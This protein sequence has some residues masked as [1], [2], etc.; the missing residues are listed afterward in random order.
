M[1]GQFFAHPF[2]QAF[3]RVQIGTVGW[4]LN[5]GKAQGFRFLPDNRRLAMPGRTIPNDDGLLVRVSRSAL[6]QMLQK[7]D[8]GETITTFLMPDQTLT[9]AEVISAIPVEPILAGWTMT[10]HP[11]SF[12]HG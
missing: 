7:S 11:I 9:L 8:S 12:T 5:K 4:Q 1:L 10:D 6:G 2:P 3:N